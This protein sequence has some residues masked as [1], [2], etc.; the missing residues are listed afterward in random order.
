MNQNL[1]EAV[2]RVYKVLVERFGRPIGDSPSTVGVPDEREEI[3]EEVR[4]KRQPKR[5][6]RVPK[7]SKIR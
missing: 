7:H 1:D 5:S 4:Q 3:S 2:D 6:L